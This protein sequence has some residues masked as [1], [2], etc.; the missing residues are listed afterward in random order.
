MRESVPL[1]WDSILAAQFGLEAHSP[2]RDSN[3]WIAF[4]VARE[5]FLEDRERRRGGEDYRLLDFGCGSAPFAMFMDRAGIQIDAMDHSQAGLA[6]AQGRVSERVRLRLGGIPELREL[7][8]EGAGG[9][10]DGVN[11]MM[12]AQFLSDAELAALAGNLFPLMSSKGLV[13]MTAHRLEYV[14][15]RAA[16]QTVPQDVHMRRQDQSWVVDHRFSS[17]GPVVPMYLRGADEFRELF[18][19]QGFQCQG[20]V[21]HLP[22]SDRFVAAHPQAGPFDVAKYMTMSFIKNA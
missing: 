20:D 19:A 22:F 8:E 14:T 17:E 9:R 1:T 2:Q 21:A 12:V 5:R 16:A 3:E 13:V 18:G 15:H 10:Y 4:P 7:V 11:L 6:M